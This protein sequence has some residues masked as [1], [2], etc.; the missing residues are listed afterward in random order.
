ML[1]VELYTVRKRHG[2]FDCH[3]TLEYDQ[4]PVTRRDQRI[5]YL[6][7]GFGCVCGEM[8]HD[9]DRGFDMPDGSF[10]HENC[11]DLVEVPA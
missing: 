6:S 1:I 11:R 10:V 2:G 9:G 8:L 4:R 5:K 3:C 7:R